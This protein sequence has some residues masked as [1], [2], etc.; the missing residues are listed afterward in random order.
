MPIG[1]GIR[2]NIATVSV[3]ERTRFRDAIVNMDDALDPAVLFPDGVTFWDK[4]EESHV[5][6][7]VAGGDVH[8]GPAFLAWHRELCNRFEQ[9]LRAVDPQLSLHYWD[10]TTDPRATP[11]PGGPVNLMTPDFMG[12][13]NGDAGP[14]FENFESTEGGVHPVIWRDMAAGLPPVPPDSDIVHSADG[15]PAAQQYAIFNNALEGAHNDIHSVY[16]G[17]TISDPH[18]SFH[19]PFVFLLHSN[20]DRL[21]AMWQRQPGQEW[22]LDPSQMYGDQ[23]GDGAVNSAMEPWNGAI[24]PWTTSPEL[25]IAKDVVADPP[26]YDTAPHSSYMIVDRDTFSLDEVDTL[27]AANPTATFGRALKVVYEGFRPDELGAPTAP[28]LT[29]TYDDASGSAVPG[30][31]FIY[32]NLLLEHPASDQA[33]RVTFE[34]DLR[35]S[36]N[37]AFGSVTELRR[38][39]VRAVHG[40]DVTDSLLTLLKQPNPYMTDG[41]VTWLS[42]DVRVFQIR[43]GWTRAGV[44]MDSD[45]YA[46]I[47]AL[48]AEFDSRSDDDFHPFLDIS[49][50][51][52]DSVLE[53]SRSVG[54]QRVYNFAVARVRYRSAATAAPDVKV[55]FRTFNTLVSALDYNT[56]KNYRRTTNGPGA[57]PLLGIQSNQIASIPYFAEGRVDT[58]SVAMTGQPDATNQKPLPATGG[59]EDSTYFGCWLDFNQ[60]EEQFPINPSGDGPFSD[61]LSIQELMRGTH[62]CMVAEI[63]FHPGP[64]DPIVIG[65]TPGSSARI[66]Q[67]NLAVVESDNPGGADS[68]KVQHTFTV[69]PSLAGQKAGTTILVNERLRP[70]EL[71]IR[72][73]NVPRDTTATLYFP[74]ISADAILA[75][76]NLRQR[77]DTIGKV[78][79]NTVK[80]QVT[81]VTFIP[82]PGGIGDDTPVLFSIQLPQTVITGQVLTVDVSQFAGRARK[83]IGA[84]QITIPVSTGALM[85]PKEI[86][87]L[88]VLKH[89]FNAIPLTDRWHPVFVRYLGEIEAKV[90]DLGGDPDSVHPSPDGTGELDATTSGRCCRLPFVFAAVL[91]FLVVLAAVAPLTIA[92]PFGA[93]GLVALLGILCWWIVSCRPKACDLL[94]GMHGG[95]VAALFVLG[96]VMLFGFVTPKL[97]VVAAL[98]AILDGVVFAVSLLRG[99]CGGCCSGKEGQK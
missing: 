88:S 89:I 12:N 4:Q 19:D 16:I 48:I 81:D 54:G 7:H 77:P 80:V 36:N 44:T 99:C 63:H 29:A 98:A 14:P 92:A 1:D 86:R 38:F 2:R 67:R 93:A 60:T 66:A 70:D 73:N 26:S 41:D 95:L 31:T 96:L 9:L 11:G 25:V 79:A 82:L 47:Q 52:Q 3:E 37:N 58:A 21:W 50:D 42:T 33:Q 43:S 62:Q 28:T 56:N 87:K 6:A 27:L 34:F 18:F 22:R 10:W 49:E 85:L 69:K 30:V 24:E 59:A 53:L 84:F 83:I 65:A 32:R 90:R 75:I 71:M 78:D 23:S 68:H 55:F 76:A 35:F 46:F 57:V 8:G 15:D 72:W 20:V 94:G 91:A 17:G 40:S 39:N 51:Q 74:E 45:P 5:A 13:A 97:V 64:D 61:R